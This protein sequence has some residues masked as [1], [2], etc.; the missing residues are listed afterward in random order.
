MSSSSGRSSL[1]GP[2]SARSGVFPE[3]DSTTLPPPQ[4]DATTTTTSPLELEHVIGYTGRFFG[5]LVGTGKVGYVKAMGSVVVIGDLNDPH[6]QHLL[7]GHDAEIC[8]LAVSANGKFAASGQVGT[9]KV[10]GFAAPVV[11]WDLPCRAARFKLRGISHRVNLVAFSPDARFVSGCGE[12]D[13]AFVWDVNTG[14]IVFATRFP[15]P[16]TMFLWVKVDVDGPRRFAY[17]IATA[18]SGSAGVDHAR[19][20][21]EPSRQQWG[22]IAAPVAMPSAGMGREY[23]C[24]VVS[25]DQVLAGTREGDLV[26]IKLVLDQEGK[27]GGTFRARLQVCTGGLLSLALRGES[28]CYAGGGDGRVRRLEVK[29]AAWTVIEASRRLDGAVVSLS[30]VGDEILAGTN[31]GKTYRLRADLAQTHQLSAAHVAPPTDLA[32]APDRSDVVA[33]CAKNGEIVVW[34]LSEYAPLATSS[35]RGRSAATCL[36]WVREASVVA[37][38]DDAHLRCFGADDGSLGWSIPDAH[39]DAITAVACHVAPDLAYLVSAAADGSVRVWNLSTRLLTMQFVEH[40][41]AV[42][43]ILVDLDNHHLFH[44]AGHDAAVLTYNIST[45][46]RTVAHVAPRGTGPF[47]AL[48]QRLDSEKELLTPDAN[49]TLLFWDCDVRD[50]PV[51]RFPGMDKTTRVRALAISP[52]GDY[53]ALANDDVLSLFRFTKDDVQAPPDPVA[54][55]LAH[56]DHINAVKWSSDQRQLVSVADDSCICRSEVIESHLGVGGS[57]GDE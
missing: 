35:P 47:T 49:G 57:V 5:T 36:A 21:F 6:D 54:H 51:S 43:A 41:R 10:P 1:F 3:V 13:L 25:N 14:E 48:A 27:K 37:G 22:L 7:R 20:K 16:L 18:Q 55:G 9:R 4:E 52:R 33:T 39:R 53:L 15:K 11:L 2:A 45:E 17:R 32:F 19:L 50:G 42:S 34:D 46:R 12:D 56:S 26:V 30:F 8:A 28:C 24:A 29:N 40:Q 23:R 31:A 38:F 44:S